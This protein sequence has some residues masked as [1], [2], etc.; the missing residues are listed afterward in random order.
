MKNL[1]E[2]RAREG[3]GGEGRQGEEEEEARGGGG[4]GGGGGG[5]G[6]TRR[7]VKLWSMINLADNIHLIEHTNALHIAK[8]RLKRKN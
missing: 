2:G 6:K 5:K 4:G 3:R 7:K 1:E 8:I